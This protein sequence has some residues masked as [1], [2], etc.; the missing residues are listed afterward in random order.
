MA[1]VR[2]AGVALSPVQQANVMDLLD[3][4]GCVLRAEESSEWIDA[5][6]SLAAIA[7]AGQKAGGRRSHDK[8]SVSIGLSKMILKAAG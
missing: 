2:Q 1:S 4:M 3:R 6:A 7:I 8:V 5:S